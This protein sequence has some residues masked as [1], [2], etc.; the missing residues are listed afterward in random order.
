MPIKLNKEESVFRNELIFAADAKQV[1]I[2]NTLVNLFML[3]RNNGVRQKQR[4]RSNDKAVTDVSRLVEMFKSLEALGIV[5][6]FSDNSQ[7]AELWIRSNLVNM[8]YRGK[9]DQEGVSSLRPIH[10]ESYKIRNAYSTRDYNSADQVYLM[11]GADPKVREELTYFLQEGWDKVTNQITHLQ[12][13]DVDS[14]GILHLIKHYGGGFMDSSTGISHIR[15]L[16]QSQ[17]NVYCEDIKRLLNYKRDIPRNVMIDYLKTITSFHLS[18]YLQKLIQVLPRMI[19]DGNTIGDPNWSIVVDLTDNVESKV[20]TIAGAD[21]ETMNNSI[22]DY[23]KATFQINAALRYLKLGK[24]SSDNLLYAITELHNRSEKFDI[25][26]DFL[27]STI[28]QNL[29]DEDRDLLEEIAKYESK[30]FDKY[31]EAI[32]KARSSY[33]YSYHVQLLDALSQKNTERGILAQGRSR[34]HPRR[35]VLGTRLL[36]ALV[37]ILV[38]RNDGTKFYTTSLSIEELTHQLRERYGLIINGNE[39]P[40]FVNS[41]VFTQ[42]AFKE[43]LAAFKLK[44]RQIGFYTELSDAYILQKV[45]PR[46]VLNA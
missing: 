1:N 15:P 46:Y 25:Y 8:V 16:L 23:I 37:Q 19:E 42:Q 20:A 38:L 26:F 18:I 30:Y 21:A 29:S 9:P 34:K 45:R 32:M 35:F 11:L 6:G 2:D 12:S 41:D 5:S 13:L 17:A 39:D 7:A 43:N 4:A 31:I 14:I 22:Y 33:L 10:L 24:T 3:L 44:L 28:V 40:R 36:E 27:W